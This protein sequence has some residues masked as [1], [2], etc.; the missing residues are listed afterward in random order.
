[1]FEVILAGLILGVTLAFM[2]G[3]VFFLLIEIS[4]SKGIKKALLFDVG[5]L[6]AD[7]AF[8]CIVLFGA[9]LINFDKNAFWIYLIGGL[10][11]VLFGLYNIASAKKKKI[12]PAD[13][14]AIAP[15]NTANWLYIAKGFF[16]N[17]INAGVFAYWLTTA[18]TLR[19][20]LQNQPDVRQLMVAYFVATIA[21]YFLTDVVKI[22]AAQRIKR[23]LTPHFLVRLEKIVGFILVLFGGYL[24]SKGLASYF[25]I[26]LA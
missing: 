23:R 18:L 7:C 9:R 22:I 6:A 14:P 24:V 13:E 20:S 2:V 8:I 21:A 10:L 1:M 12:K 17:I 4:L 16:L 19:A 26:A 25:D 5:V 3:P 15:K 11:I